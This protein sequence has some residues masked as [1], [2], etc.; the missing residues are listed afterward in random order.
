MPEA[1]ALRVAARYVQ[2]REFNSPEALKDYL[3]EHPQA[4]KSKH[5]VKKDHGKEHGE[6]HGEHEEAPK[7]SWKERL[8]G[9]SEKA[10][11]LVKNAP[12]AVH[13]FIEDDAFRR[14]TLQEAH[15]SLTEAPEKLVKNVVKTVK[16]EVKE[17]KEAGEGIAAVMKGG[18]M[19]AH[20]KK[21]LKT[22][23]T[24]LAIGVAAAALTA[25]GPLAAAGVFGKGLA[26]HVAMK[27]VSNALGHAHVLEE[28]GHIGHGVKH[29]M[30]HLAAEKKAP[31]VDTVMANFITAAVAKELQSLSDED[32]KKAL[33]G[34]EE[35]EGGKKKEASWKVVAT[36]PS[37]ILPALHEALEVHDDL[38]KW[39]A[40]FP[41]VLKTAKQETQGLPPGWVWQDR[42]VRF[43]EAYDNREAKL[44]GLDDTLQ[45][46]ATDRS[47]VSDIAK[48]ARVATKDPPSTARISSAIDDFQFFEH[49]SGRDQ[50]AY[51]VRSLASWAAAFEKW[52]TASSHRLQTDIR[53]ANRRIGH[54]IP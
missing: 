49:P 53:E 7:K 41:S 40:V 3:H 25:S 2:S 47:L 33:E 4:D 31:D 52:A 13:Q 43:F 10:T 37:E 15:K 28:L 12:K 21:A 32:I 50:I 44:G 39:V 14:K 42:F 20:Q 35:E 26:K 38:R 19:N 30:E 46:I 17:Y 5:T 24:H 11:N 1:I 54:A 22:V 29:L 51:N 34:A 8:K 9:L 6:G 16:H 23:A 27:A 45:T 48:N 18:K 36:D